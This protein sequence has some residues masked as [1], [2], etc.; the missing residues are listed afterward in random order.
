MTDTMA[1]PTVNT[2]AV[3][4]KQERKEKHR[5]GH[6]HE[7]ADSKWTHGT[8]QCCSDCRNCCRSFICP[9]WQ[10]GRLRQYTDGHKC[11][12]ECMTCFALTFCGLWWV[13]QMRNREDIRLKYNIPGTP[14]KDCCV[15]FWFAPCALAQAGHELKDREGQ[16]R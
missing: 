13:V 10:Y 3:E 2:G 12:G 6:C 11:F 16:P 4:T 1:N 15:S 8:C 5:G 9:C 7:P 14:L